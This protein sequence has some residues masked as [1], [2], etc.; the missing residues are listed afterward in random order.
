MFDVDERINKLNGA[1]RNAFPGREHK[2]TYR[3]HYEHFTEEL[4]ITVQQHSNK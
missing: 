4:R 2:M 1:G 3:K